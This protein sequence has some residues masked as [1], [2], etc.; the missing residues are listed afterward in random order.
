MDVKLVAALAN[1]PLDPTTESKLQDQFDETL[2]TVAKVNE[3][4]TSGIEPTSQVTGLVNITREDTI[5]PSRILSQDQALSQ[6]RHTHNGY[7]VVPAV[8]DAA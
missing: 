4:N 6:A 8:L 2:K 1:L 5:D 7:F 3:L